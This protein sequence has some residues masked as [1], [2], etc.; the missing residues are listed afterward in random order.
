MSFMRC[1]AYWIG[2]SLCI[3]RQNHFPVSFCSSRVSTICSEH[4][5]TD[6]LCTHRSLI[7]GSAYGSIIGLRF[8]RI[9]GLLTQNCIFAGISHPL[10]GI[11]LRKSL[12]FLNPPIMTNLHPPPRSAYGFRNF[13]LPHFSRSLA[14]SSQYLLHFSLWFCTSQISS[15]SSTGLLVDMP[16]LHFKCLLQKSV[17][18]RARVLCPLLSHTVRSL[19][20][21][22]A[23]Y[24]SGGFL[25]NW[26][27]VDFTN[28]FIPHPTENIT[29]IIRSL[30]FCILS[31]HSSRD[32]RPPY[33]PVLWS[34]ALSKIRLL[35]SLLSL[36]FRFSA[37]LHF[38]YSLPF[39][40]RKNCVLRRF[41]T[42]TMSQ[43]ERVRCHS[44]PV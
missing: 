18:F 20:I 40:D 25:S 3:S 15:I 19:I 6:F 39:S 16:K 32:L 17:P 14:Q 11:F 43:P 31:T 41:C 38:P 34:P 9:S 5:S 35:A 28:L 10:R 1:D 37:P 13:R 27:H 24:Y 4:K 22:I 26:I 21:S 33:S 23:T 12:P 8:A 7:P 36:R 2:I 42:W 44:C 29:W 30:L